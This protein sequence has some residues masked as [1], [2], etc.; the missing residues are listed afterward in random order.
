MSIPEK[1][2]FCGDSIT[3]GNHSLCGDP[4]HIMG[5]GFAF[6]AAAYLGAEYPLCN[7]KSYNTACSGINSD[8]LLS[9]WEE[10]VLSIKP[11]VLTLLVGIND[12]N[13]LFDH[14]KT[15]LQKKRAT[16]AAYG[17]NLRYM[18]HLARKCNPQMKIL[19]GMPFYFCVDEL[20]EPSGLRQDEDERKFI[21]KIRE[22]SQAFRQEKL[23]DVKK[24]QQT[25]RE[26][27]DCF[28]AYLL[29]FQQ[30]FQDAVQMAP[31][32]H[33][34]WDGVHPTVSGH[35]LMFNL[36]KKVCR[37]NILTGCAPGAANSME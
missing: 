29:D 10:R 8:R 2:L 12:T 17:E 36:W 31:L 23:A 35:M 37:E 16:P 27:A 34:I 9:S 18:L 15:L 25:V 21:L 11:D 28:G 20:P 4:N 26:L 33:W 5:H 19:L 6:M 1:W 13:T 14:D 3:D 7:I 22:Y 24:R 32:E 30:V